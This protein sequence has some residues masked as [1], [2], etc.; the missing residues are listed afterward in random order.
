MEMKDYVDKVL[1]AVKKDPSLLKKLDKEPAKTLE[2]I[3]GI[4]LPDDEVNAIAAKLKGK[5]IFETISNA[6]D[7]ASKLKDN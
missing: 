5:N 1:D 2:S 4:D 6:K 3:L 7:F